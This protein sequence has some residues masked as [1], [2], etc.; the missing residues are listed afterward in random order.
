MK[1][2][3]HGV[4]DTFSNRIESDVA[5]TDF[6]ELGRILYE[7]N[8]FLSSKR[9]DNVTILIDKISSATDLDALK[10]EVLEGN[11]YKYFKDYF[12]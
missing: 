5:L 8:S 10:S 3:F 7:E 6:D 9:A 2:K 1:S 12:T 11:F 4:R